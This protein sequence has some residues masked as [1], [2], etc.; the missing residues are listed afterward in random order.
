MLLFHKTKEKDTNI[1]AEPNKLRPPK[2]PN[3]FL[4]KESQG[5]KC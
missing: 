2:V 3:N 5:E 4:K 1:P